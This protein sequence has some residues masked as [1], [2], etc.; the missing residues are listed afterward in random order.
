[1]PQIDRLLA[2]VKKR[3][4][5]DLHLAAGY[6]A[7]VRLHGE[8]V[9]LSTS[10]LT[11]DMLK[12]M[13]YEIMIPQQVQAFESEWDLDFAYALEQVARFRANLFCDKRG[14]GA[15]FRII[16]TEIQ[17]I[18]GM[19]LPP[20]IK[21]L[22]SFE[23]G[24]I[25][26]TGPTGSGKSTT[27]SAMINHVNENREGHIITVEDPIEFV[28][29]P[30]KC[31]ITQREIH[32]DAR[33]F[34]SA[35]RAAC[36]ED[37]DVVLVGELRD[38]ETISLALTAAE[39]GILVYGTLHTNS[40]AKTIDRIIDVFP[41]ESQPQTRTMLADSLKGVVA[42][43]LLR[44]KDG[45]G[46]CAAIEILVG[47]PALSNLIREGKNAL[48][49]S[50]MQTGSAEGMITMDQSLLSLVQQGK[51]DRQEAVLRAHDKSLFTGG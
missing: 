13:L 25:L 51:I 3:G 16:P 21:K 7:M 15:A 50:L 29:P 5:S 27:L 9:N 38:L 45:R 48:V 36:R 10:P 44:T 35:L 37:P 14:V 41:V 30:K 2:E 1:V 6:P 4:A 28:H 12:S 19:K 42:Q 11:N 26:V 47:S 18:D 43:Q 46:R 24:L 23:K 34:P 17:T 20:A 8:I 40:A 39:L 32:Y 33:S 31:M 49:Y 22:A